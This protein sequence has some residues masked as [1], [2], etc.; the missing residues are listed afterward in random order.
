MKGEVRRKAVEET[1]VRGSLSWC[2]VN[3]FYCICYYIW[4]ITNLYVNVGK[5]C[6]VSFYFGLV[7]ALFYHPNSLQWTEIHRIVMFV[8][9]PL[10]SEKIGPSNW[11]HLWELH[12]KFRHCDVSVHQR[13]QGW[14][15]D[16]IF[17]HY[18]ML[19]KE[20]RKGNIL[21][22]K[23]SDQISVRP[24]LHVIFLDSKL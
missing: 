14:S 11:R 23:L 4:Y 3:V 7:L 24:R 2:S 13:V 17:A 1:W 16:D 9:V 22:H 12:I 5:L 8:A 15:I 6:V 19:N 10:L 20:K 18:I 21:V